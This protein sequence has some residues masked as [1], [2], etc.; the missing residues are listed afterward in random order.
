M[1]SADRAAVVTCPARAVIAA[2][3]VSMGASCAAVVAADAVVAAHDAAHCIGENHC[4]V[5]VE[6][7]VGAAV[8]EPWRVAITCVGARRDGWRAAPGG[9]RVALTRCPARGFPVASG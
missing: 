3:D 4:E 1:A 9:K 7:A 8:A 5:S 6:Q 2:V